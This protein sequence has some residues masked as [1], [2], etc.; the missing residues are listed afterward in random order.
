MD[1]ADWRKTI[2]EIDRKLVE[3]V[4]QRAHAARE[5]G[6]LKREQRLAVYEPEREREILQRICE[7]NRG[8]LSDGE[9][10]QVY[11]RL[12]EVMRRLQENDLHSERS[13]IAPAAIPER[14]SKRGS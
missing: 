11:E 14:G 2:D 5:I 3:L 13:T 1:I 6:R 12:I 8:P 10:T 9:L 4:N 7:L